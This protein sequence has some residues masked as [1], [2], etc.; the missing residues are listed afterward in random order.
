VSLSKVEAAPYLQNTLLQHLDRP[1]SDGWSPAAAGPAGDLR[2]DHAGPPKLQATMEDGLPPLDA[3]WGLADDTPGPS[4]ETWSPA[5][6][7]PVT[8]KCSPAL[9]A[10]VAE[11]A[12][13]GRRV[14]PG[15]CDV[16]SGARH[17]G[18]GN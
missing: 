18:S 11:T 10:P 4:V 1:P 12:S 7:A 15:D 8:E 2:Q 16:G 5:V 3:S 9:A 14:G 17:V 6:A 13:G